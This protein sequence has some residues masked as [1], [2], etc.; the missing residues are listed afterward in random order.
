MSAGIRTLNNDSLSDAL[1]HLTAFLEYARGA[2]E[3]RRGAPGN[4]VISGLVHAEEEGKKL[5]ESELI[6]MIVVLLLAGYETTANLI[7]N[8]MLALF[9]HP[10]ELAK[11][12]ANPSLIQSAVEEMLRYDTSTETFQLRFAAEDVE[13]AGAT[14]PKGEPVLMVVTSANRDKARFDAPDEFDITRADNKHLAFGVG[15]R[16]CVGAPLARLEARIAISTLLRRM[17]DVRLALPDEEIRYRVS[18]LR[19]GPRL[20]GIA[21]FPVVF[22]PKG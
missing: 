18:P 22:T 17:P 4:D 1:P 14:I 19:G 12:K 9:R 21:A 11:L 7:G 5:S 15:I 20:R 6:S 3:A 8:G 10:G 13:I 16:Y 2:C